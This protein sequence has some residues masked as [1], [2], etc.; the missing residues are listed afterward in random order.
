[1]GRG[2]PAFCHLSH[3]QYCKASVD[4]CQVTNDREDIRGSEARIGI[5]VR[6]VREVNPDRL[7]RNSLH[8]SFIARS[9]KGNVA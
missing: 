1:M 6:S 4:S 5:G 3:R 2:R 7:C 8:K 9:L